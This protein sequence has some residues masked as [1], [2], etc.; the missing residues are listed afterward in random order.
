[1][2]TEAAPEPIKSPPI[3]AL[4]DAFPPVINAVDF[5]AAPVLPPPD[6]IPGLFHQEGKFAFGGGSKTH[7]S[8]VFIDLG[9]SIASGLDWLGFATVKTR[10]LY[11]NFEIHSGFFWQRL[12]A[13]AAA[14]KLDP[15]QANL[16][17][18]NLRGHQVDYKSLLPKVLAVAKERQ[19]GLVIT[20]PIYKLYGKTDENNAGDVAELLGGIERITTVVGA[21]IAFAAHFSKGN[22]AQK[23]A[24]DRISGSGVFGRDPDT[25]VNITPHKEPNCFTVDIVL[26]N[27]APLAS[28]VVEWQKPLLVRV[29]HLDPKC[30]KPAGGKPRKRSAN[31]LLVILK[32]KPGSTTA[33]FQR[34][35]K[36]EI[37]IASSTFY[38]LLSD[39]RKLPGVSQSPDDLWTVTPQ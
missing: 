25:I 2:S 34:Y 31:D 20:D 11:I 21:G 24:I 37:G 27:Y 28:F 26:R 8:W 6:L 15:R 10:V 29:P 16:D 12:N 19:Y 23:E 18:W 36:A 17:L 14:K 9:L 5:M 32:R 33:D 22:Q 30:L 3:T 4:P 35:A 39:L 1:M 7:K 13:I 38:D